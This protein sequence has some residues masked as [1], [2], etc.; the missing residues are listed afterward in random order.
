MLLRK[1]VIFG[2]WSLCTPFISTRD[3]SSLATHHWGHPATANSQ[4]SRKER[5]K[6]ERTWHTYPEKEANSWAIPQ[7]RKGKAS[8]PT[9]HLL[10]F[11]RQT[12]SSKGP[13]PSQASFS[14]CTMREMLKDGLLPSTGRSYPVSSQHDFL[15][16]TYQKD[17]SPSPRAHTGLE[18]LLCQVVL[19]QKLW[20]RAQ[21]NL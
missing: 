4:L 7:A 8:A 20:P 13:D 11:S 16:I 14:T 12:A 1:D 10:T 15:Q 18:T 2:L 19:L 3:Q 5:W 9:T 17:V 21:S 6:R